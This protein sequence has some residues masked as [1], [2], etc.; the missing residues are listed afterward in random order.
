LVGDGIKDAI[1]EEHAPALVHDLVGAEVGVVEGGVGCE[2]GHVLFLCLGHLQLHVNALK[3]NFNSALFKLK[4]IE[5]ELVGELILGR[6]V[7]GDPGE[8]SNRGGGFSVGLD[9]GNEGFVP[10]HVALDD[11]SELG[12]CFFG[13]LAGEDHLHLGSV[14]E[15]HEFGPA[16]ALPGKL[17]QVFYLLK[18]FFR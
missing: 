18:D 17:L 14:L 11:A 3:F 2:D 8:L 10:R 9:L 12:A 7:Q 6:F 13:Y 1:L 16:V 4:L 15:G 5:I